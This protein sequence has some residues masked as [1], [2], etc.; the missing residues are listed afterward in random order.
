MFT[1]AYMSSTFQGC[2]SKPFLL[3]F[4]AVAKVTCTV[5]S[6]FLSDKS[7]LISHQAHRAVKHLHIFS[8]IDQQ[9]FKGLNFSLWLSALLSVCKATKSK[10][11][12]KCVA[13]SSL[14]YTKC[15]CPVILCYVFLFISR[16]RLSIFHYLH[17]FMAI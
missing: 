16:N 4:S 12:F 7:P 14:C 6:L 15:V 17:R 9:M 13:N 11:G 10:Q 1:C 5:T 3:C 2:E 8:D